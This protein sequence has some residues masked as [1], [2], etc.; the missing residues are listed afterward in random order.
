MTAY[1][2][3]FSYKMKNYPR[4]QKVKKIWYFDYGPQR[5]NIILFFIWKNFEDM[6]AFEEYIFLKS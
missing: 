1:I 2:S 3:L 4:G 6:E 5:V